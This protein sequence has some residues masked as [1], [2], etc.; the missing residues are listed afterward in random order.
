M[1]SI[2]FKLIFV[3]FAVFTV[4]AVNEGED[5]LMKILTKECEEMREERKEMRDMFRRE[6]ARLDKEDKRQQEENQKLKKHNNQQQAQ[7]AKLD[8]RQQE[9]NQ[10]LKEQNN[11][12]LED[13]IAKLSQKLRRA[14]AKMKQSIRQKDP[15]NSL[16][17]TMLKKFIRQDDINSELKKM[18]KNEVQA[19]LKG[20]CQTGDF[21]TTEGSSISGDNTGFTT[22]RTINFL[23]FQSSPKVTVA[24]K[25]FVR[26]QAQSSSNANDDRTWGIKLSVNS[27]TS[28]S[29]KIQV[30]GDNT[31]VSLVGVQWIACP[32]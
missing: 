13:Q 25:D 5:D 20:A 19:L 6:T 26:T 23:G 18:I 16:E 8:E 21:Q 15:N 24:I 11:N 28:T 2:A 10:K 17:V 7:I 12:K 30:V 14:N 31:Y 22:T 3:A 9:D 1:E 32:Q 29:A 4:L 27:V